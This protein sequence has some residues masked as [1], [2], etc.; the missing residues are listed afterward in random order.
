MKKSESKCKYVSKK[1]RKINS[2]TKGNSKRSERER[3]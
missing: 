2:K 3:E 1:E